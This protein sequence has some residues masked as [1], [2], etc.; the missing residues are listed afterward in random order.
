MQDQNQPKSEDLSFLDKIDSYEKITPTQ[1]TLFTLKEPYCKQVSKVCVPSNDT[2]VKT[3]LTDHIKLESAKKLLI[4]V[5]H[6]TEL[7]GKKNPDFYDTKNKNFQEL[8]KFAGEYAL[9]RKSSFDV[10][11]YCWNG[12]NNSKARIEAGKLLAVLFD[13]LAQRYKKIITLSQSHGASVTNIASNHLQKISI[14]TMVHFG[15]PVREHG[16]LPDYKPNN[17]RLLVNLFSLHDL[18]QLLGVRLDTLEEQEDSIKLYKKLEQQLIELRKREARDKQVSLCVSDQEG[19]L[20][21]ETHNTISQLGKLK[22][23]ML[24]GRVYDQQLGRSVFNVEFRCDNMRPAHGELPF[25]VTPV[26]SLLLDSLEQT[27]GI[28]GN[29]GKTWRDK[30]WKRELR[31]LFDRFPITYHCNRN[32]KHERPFLLGLPVFRNSDVRKIDA[33]EQPY[34]Q[35]FEYLEDRL[36]SSSSEDK[37][38]FKK[39]FGKDIE[40]QD[41]L[42]YTLFSLLFKALR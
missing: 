1:Q 17:F 37:K 2:L 28:L 41:S 4:L 24:D 31:D 19:S 39:L 32:T 29:G 36:V 21:N 9:K 12:E 8:L 42:A 13:A 5:V 25:K 15:S 14:D 18:I 27:V 10:L 30:P 35:G 22:G 11:A 26:L 16:D 7:L 38:I 33:G 34:A 6:G 23:L 3:F 40:E 20:V